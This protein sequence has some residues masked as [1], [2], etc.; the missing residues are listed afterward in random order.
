[1]T[2]IVSLL[3]LL[4]IA[5][6]V[7]IVALSKMIVALNKKVDALQTAFN[8]PLKT[9]DDQLKVIYERVDKIDDRIPVIIGWCETLRENQDT[10]QGDLEKAFYGTKKDIRKVEKQQERL[11]ATEEKKPVWPR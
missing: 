8:E 5:T 1:M 11:A 9:L 3:T 2:I 4:A 7:A 6:I 10:L